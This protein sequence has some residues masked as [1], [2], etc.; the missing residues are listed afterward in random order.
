[1]KFAISPASSLHALFSLFV[2][3]DIS[4]FCPVCF[5]LV[6]RFSFPF[7]VGRGRGSSSSFLSFIIP[8]HP[9]PHP[10]I[11]SE[12]ANPI[13]ISNWIETWKFDFSFSISRPKLKTEDSNQFLLLNCL[14]FVWIW[15]FEI[16]VPDRFIRALLC[17]RLFNLR[18]QRWVFI[19]DHLFITFHYSFCWIL[20][21]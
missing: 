10:P 6:F 16:H 3:L 13:R 1:M 18:I 9:I 19:F 21:V 17:F 7:M 20:L 14:T 11:P 4:W 5:G 15:K 2:L 12:S 8:H